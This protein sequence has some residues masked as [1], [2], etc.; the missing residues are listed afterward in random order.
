MCLVKALP[1]D[2]VPPV[3]KI[4]FPFFSFK[5]YIIHLDLDN[6]KKSRILLEK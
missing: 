1:R 3:I 4:V 6:G 2:P 5:Y